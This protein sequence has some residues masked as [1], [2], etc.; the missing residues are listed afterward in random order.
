MRASVTRA[1]TGTGNGPLIAWFI[2]LIVAAVGFVGVG[3]LTGTPL[4]PGL[5]G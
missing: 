3:V 5:P 2:A 4:Y 1:Q